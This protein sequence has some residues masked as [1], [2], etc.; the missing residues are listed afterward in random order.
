MLLLFSCNCERMGTM[1]RLRVLVA[2]VVAVFT[3]SLSVTGA[4]ALPGASQFCSD[5]GE[6][7]FATHGQCVSTVQTFFNSGNADP[8]AL[9]RIFGN[10]GFANQGQCVSFL[11]HEGF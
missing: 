11:R 3:L 5:S 6:F 8:V 9:C 10:G 7:G 4:S 2:V 1:R